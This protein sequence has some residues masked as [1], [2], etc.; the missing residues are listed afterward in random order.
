MC[1]A[2]L[3]RCPAQAYDCKAAIRFLRANAAKHNFA[4]DHFGVGGD[5]SG[6]YLAAFVGASGDV[7]E[8]EGDLG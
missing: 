5:P 7:K 4:P 2:S 3:R 6:G 1:P 8:T